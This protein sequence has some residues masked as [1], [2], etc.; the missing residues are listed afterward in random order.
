MLFLVNQRLYQKVHC[1]CN[2]SPHSVDVKNQSSCFAVVTPDHD[3]Q[4]FQTNNQ[5]KFHHMKH[6]FLR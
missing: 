6:H 5:E 3:F 1:L 4:S 2:T